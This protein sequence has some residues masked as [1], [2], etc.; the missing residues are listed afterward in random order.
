[1]ANYAIVV[2]KTQAMLVSLNAEDKDDQKVELFRG[3][4]VQ[5]K[6][7]QHTYTTVM[8]CGFTV[9]NLAFENNLY[10]VKTSSLKFLDESI[11]LLML[12]IPDP[13]ERANIAKDQAYLDYLET[14]KLNSF[15]QVN[16]HHFSMCPIRQSL[17]FIPEREKEYRDRDY[18]CIVR[19]IGFVNEI[20][21]GHFFGLELLVI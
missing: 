16:A 15:V 14:L 10:Y 5:V 12:A 19:Y 8:I 21:P 17:Q 2:E 13:Q 1:M 7:V 3:T 20:G 4:T 6:R 9:D 18:D 11:W